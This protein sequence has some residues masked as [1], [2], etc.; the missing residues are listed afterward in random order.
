MDHLTMSPLP[1][2]S[3]RAAS[4]SSRLLSYCFTGVLLIT[5][6][7]LGSSC[8]DDFTEVKSSDLSLDPRQVTFSPGNTGTRESSRIFELRNSGE[9]PLTVSD[10]YIDAEGPE[11]RA[12]IEGGLAHPLDLGRLVIGFDFALG[13][14][15]P[16]LSGLFHFLFI[17]QP[18]LLHGRSLRTMV[19]LAIGVLTSLVNKVVA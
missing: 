6:T 8:G 3:H 9:G 15:A 7:L 1:R 12:R 13:A 19:P 4:S 5:A 14:F 10:I 17:D 2:L 16:S 11:G 18:L